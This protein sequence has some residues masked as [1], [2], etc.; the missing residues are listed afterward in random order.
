MGDVEHEEGE[1]MYLWGT[2]LTIASI[3]KRV[4]EFYTGFRSSG[5]AETEPAKYEA[6]I[7]QVSCSPPS[8]PPDRAA[9]NGALQREGGAD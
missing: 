8:A 2:N 1:D 4:R 5:Q 3:T 6:L 7:R 9:A